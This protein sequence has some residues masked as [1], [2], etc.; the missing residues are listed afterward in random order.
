MCGFTGVYHLNGTP[1]PVALVQTMNA[2]LVHRGPDDQGLTAI[3]TATGRSFSSGDPEGCNLVM[4]SRRLSI[5]DLS[6]AGRM[7]MS[8]PNQSIWLVYNGEIYNYREV[9]SKLESLGHVFRSGTDTEVIIEAYQEWGTACLTHFN[10]MWSFA[11]YDV[12]KRQL[13]CSRDRLGIKPFYFFFDGKTFVFGSEIKSILA[14]PGLRFQ[15]NPQAMFNYLARSYRFVDGRPTTF[16]EGIRQ[17]EPG[18][19]L[20]VDDRGIEILSYWRLDPSGIQDHDYTDEQYVGRYLELLDD[21]VRLRLRSD[22]PVAVQLSGGLDSSAVAVLAARCLGTG[23]PVFSACYDEKPFDER[24]FIAPTV[25]SIKA[26]FTPIFPRP[27]RLLE[28]LPPMIRAFD[29]PICT[30]TFFAHWQVMAEVHRQGYKVILNGHG[31][32]ELA[33]GYY[34]HFLHHFGDLR[35]QGANGRL[36]AEVKAWL[37]NHGRERADHLDEY[38]KLLDVGRPY[39][40]DYLKNFTPYE[41]ALGPALK[42][43]TVEPK[44]NQDIFDSLLTNRLY[45]E[46]RYETLPAVLKAEDRVSMAFSIESRLPFLDYRLVEFMFSVPNALKIKNGLGKYI[47]RQA[48]AGV[49]PEMVRTRSEKVGFNAPSE[50]WFRTYLGH[51]FENLCHDSILYDTGLLDRAGFSHLWEEH[52]SGRANHYQ[53]LWQVLNLD[54]WIREYFN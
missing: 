54:I 29:E 51:S 30:V 27:D 23:L 22:V 46:L 44:P 15:P 5:I 35:R 52:R 2:A 42:S 32:D 38:F 34:D 21:S 6:S 19:S 9:R 8:N 37:A 26:R 50:K 28:E 4:A 17:I 11:L 39:M 33:A 36:D 1:V 16:F 40:E 45:N 13:F 49:I 48:L 10:G 43:I 7:P 25:T 20:L 24:D 31:A 14:H 41:N 12:G 53:Y 47:Q 3:A 18:C